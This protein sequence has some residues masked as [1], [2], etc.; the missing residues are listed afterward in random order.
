MNS[1]IFN[2]RQILVL[3]IFL[4]FSIN[5]SIAANDPTITGQVRIDIQDAMKKYIDKQ[6][7]D[8]KLYVFD[9]VQNK[10][11]KLTFDNLHSKVVNDGGFYISCADFI[12]QDGSKV[13]LDFMVRLS[14]NMYVM[15][16]TIV[17]KVNGK[18]RPYHVSDRVE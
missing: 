17:H 5:I 8:G 11:L 7:A 1:A 9:A 16:Q 6:T 15:N 14:D 10:L 13:D 3:G 18:K 2:V 4:L 12:D